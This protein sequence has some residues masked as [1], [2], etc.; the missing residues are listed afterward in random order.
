MTTP[1]NA[2]RHLTTVLDHWK[3]GTRD[4]DDPVVAAD[5]AAAIE[6]LIQATLVRHEA[7]GDHSR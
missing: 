1:G 2:R 3:N 7:A 5:V 4:G 6:D